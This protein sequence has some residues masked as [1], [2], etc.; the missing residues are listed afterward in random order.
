MRQVA[1]RIEHVAWVVLH[2]AVRRA[3]AVDL[4]RRQDDRPDGIRR[5]TAE[6][7][8]RE[9]VARL[10][11]RV[12]LPRAA[13][14]HV[15][16]VHVA[17]QASERRPDAEALGWRVR[18]ARRRRCSHRARP[19][20]VR[21][22]LPDRAGDAHRVRPAA[23]GLDDDDRPPRRGRRLPS[24]IA[25]LRQARE[26][27]VV[28]QAVAH[29]LGGV[30]SASEI[31]HRRPGD[32]HRE[33]LP[34][35]RPRREVLDLHR[36]GRGRRGGDHDGAEGDERNADRGGSH[37]GR[38][39]D[40]GAR[41]AVGVDDARARGGDDAGDEVGEELVQRHAAHRG[42]DGARDG[43]ARGLAGEVDA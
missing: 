34:G 23:A 43:L 19:R 29:V 10:E 6:A 14:R 1:R 42:V 13:E 31:R 38:D 35:V 20:R 28:E 7:P 37:R 25:V 21:E 17:L 39:G 2:G 15:V 16:D 5:T 32:R 12:R 26:V 9:L 24:A 36:I 4:H 33:V 18:G 30:G 8:L 41:C 40:D 27:D 22:D 3:A 11:L